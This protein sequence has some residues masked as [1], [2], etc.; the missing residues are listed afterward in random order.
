M[1]LHD[2]YD[3][4]SLLNLLKQGDLKAFAAIHKRYYGILYI[5]AYKM[6][7][8]REE[9]KDLL[10]ELFTGLWNNRDEINFDLN[11]KGYLYTAARNRILNI[12]KHQKVKSAYISSFKLFIDNNSPSADKQYRMKELA[13]LIEAEVSS[14]PPQMRLIFEMSRN[15]NLSHNEI[16][17]QLNISPLTVRKQVNNSLKILRIKLAVHFFSFFLIFIYSIATLRLF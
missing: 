8:D 3:D 5:H 2:S 12:F 7:P 11:L 10:Q 4:C 1:S 13:A 15:A 6:F 16:A 14:L 17:L 9:V